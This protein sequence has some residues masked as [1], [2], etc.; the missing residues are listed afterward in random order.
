MN[1]TIAFCA[2]A[3]L[4]AAGCGYV[5][6]PLLPGD[7]KTVR[8]DIF[9]NETLRQ[10]LEL[11]VSKAVI[12]EL[13]SSTRLKVTDSDPDSVLKGT[14]TATPRDA[15]IENRFGTVT[16]GYVTLEVALVWTDA[17][18]DREIPLRR[19]VVSARTYY[20]VGR[21]ENFAT[22][23]NKAAEILGRKVVEAMEEEW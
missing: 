6:K 13:Q 5:H 21:G 17:R 1:R 2:A 12:D 4:L 23:V 8:I 22:A 11:T 19:K 15:F 3:L 14:L 7:I 10:D 16:S 18:T 9:N 20:N